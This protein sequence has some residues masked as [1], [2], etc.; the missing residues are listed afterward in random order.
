MSIRLVPFSAPVVL[1]LTLSACTMVIEPE[2]HLR[3]EPLVEK[4]PIAVGVY[5]SDDLRD[6]LHSANDPEFGE[7]Q[8]SLGPPS[9]AL[10]DEIF[11]FTFE[12]WRPVASI[13]PIAGLDA[14][15]FAG[16]IAPRIERVYASCSDIRNCFA[17][18]GYAFTLYAMDGSEIATWDTA[19][20]ATANLEV[21]I[22]ASSMVFMQFAVADKRMS[23]LLAEAM[24]D[25]GVSFWPA[26]YDNPKIQEWLDRVAASRQP[27]DQ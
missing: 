6:Y 26:F 22:L 18:I 21:E 23:E 13:P 8:T 16:V 12:S 3:R 9:I 10:L 27:A 5:Y 11:G 25:A 1:C 4:L 17:T 15:Q 7:W 19:G 24:A 20:Y 2:P 14:N